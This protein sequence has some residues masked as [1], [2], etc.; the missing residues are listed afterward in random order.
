M[1]HILITGA[2][3]FV[4]R[5]LASRLQEEPQHRLTLIDRA[6]DGAPAAPRTRQIPGS[7]G[8]AAVLDAALD[9][10][11]DIVF[12]LASIPGSL[13]EREHAL[14]C[15]VNLLATLALAH[16]LAAQ[17]RRQ[18][19]APRLVFASSVAVYGPLGAET[20][21]EDQPPRPAIS[22]GAHKL[23]AEIELADLSR[24][25]ELDAVSLR[26]PGIVARPATESGHGSA[27]M[28]LVMHRLAAGEPYACPVSAQATAWWMSLACCI[29]NLLHAAA[30]STAEAPASRS[31]QLPVLRLSMEQVL[32]ALEERYGAHCRQL[33]SYAPD[34][35]IEALFG[36]YPGL[37]TP[38]A[39]AAGFRHDGDAGRLIQRALVQ[40]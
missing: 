15:Q 16:R 17:G 3:G 18:R 33:L 6:F 34:A 31:W 27:F 9:E 37:A 23:M 22:Y 14:G 4:G 28:S 2:G 26:L 11:A 24:R 7:F 40:C 36:R 8:D 21:H 10:P 35:A 12:H 25:G 19:R 30:M 5:A 29:E 1:S 13:A 32:A 38:G 20:V 39:L